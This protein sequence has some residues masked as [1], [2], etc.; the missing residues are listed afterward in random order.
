MN[1]FICDVRVVT[2]PPSSGWVETRLT[3]EA[4]ERIERYIKKS[5]QSPESL[6][7]GLAGNISYSHSLKDEDDWFYNNVLSKC[8]ETYVNAFNPLPEVKYFLNRNIGTNV[9][10]NAFELKTLWVNYQKKYEFNPLHNHS[11]VFSFVLWN[12][13]P[14]KFVDE[15]S[16]EFLSGCSRPEPSA[17][18][19]TYP[20]M[21]GE[22]E[23]YHYCVEDDMT[24]KL[25]FFPSRLHHSVNPFYSSDEVRISVSGNIDFK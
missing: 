5:Q 22:L 24:D 6:K 9:D 16:Q 3:K 21:L 12:T 18:K 11:G 15:I 23:S 19:F 20:G 14:Y 2:P 10:K 13:I 1:E 7:G 25:V 17:F 4:S 8:I